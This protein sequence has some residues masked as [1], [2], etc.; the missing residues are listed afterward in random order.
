MKARALKVNAIEL[1]QQPDGSFAVPQEE[2]PSE[3]N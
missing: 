2:Q 3:Q 1:D